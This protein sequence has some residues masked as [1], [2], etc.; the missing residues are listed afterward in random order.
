MMHEDFGRA[1]ADQVEAVSAG[2]YRRAAIALLIAIGLAGAIPPVYAQDQLVALVRP[3][4]WPGVSGLIG[5]GDRLWLVNSV[6]FVN[7][8]SADVYSYDPGTG[9]ARY[10]RHLFSQD[11]GDPVVADG[12]LYWPFEDS[13]MSLGRGEFM[14]TNS[15]TWRWHMLPQGLTFHIHAMAALDGRLFAATSAWRGGLQVSADQGRSWR[16][17]YDH[18]TPDGFVSRFTV[19]ATHNGTLYAGLTAWREDGPRL[20]R[21]DGDTLVQAPGFPEGRAIPRMT[22]FG[23]DLYAT[24]TGGGG[25]ALWRYD[26]KTA[27]PVEGLTGYWVRDMAVGEDIWA[28]TV[29]GEGGILWRSSDGRNWE[30]VQQFPDG[31]P[32]D[33]ELYAGSVY[34]G[35]EG[36]DG[37]GTLWGPPSS[38]RVETD[39]TIAADVPRPEPP[40][41][42]DAAR[43]DLLATL[44]A[45][46]IEPKT[47]ERHAGALRAALL[48]LFDRED[49]QIGRELG[50][51]LDAAF[52]DTE[53]GLIGGRV[54]ISA[55]TL[56]RWNLLWA[57]ARI[58]HGHV[59]LSYLTEK[60]TTENN[61]AEKYFGL[62]PLAAW[63]IARLGQSDE[64]TIEALIT[65]LE[66]N[67]DPL[68]LTGDIVGALSAVTGQRFGYDI[69]AWHRWWSARRGG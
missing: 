44:D 61:R 17:A 30:Q 53:V 48:P 50:K 52:P 34:V 14:V 7:H 32:L 40:V 18:P 69:A 67:D 64:K 9:M 60:W 39:F 51:R 10:E 58:E 47:Y 45:A 56:A 13:R 42:A 49:A 31:A 19:L 33:V 22:S 11:A 59:P 2:Q 20:F 63:T 29:E 3:G 46:L 12:L 65:R 5:Y 68:W 26:G 27:E 16:V 41:K 66:R 6:K 35:T 28:V 23:G 43:E 38:A 4:P 1:V 15:S 36:P 37:R 57:M 21:Y 55:A 54:M 25:S 24:L 8:N 62:P